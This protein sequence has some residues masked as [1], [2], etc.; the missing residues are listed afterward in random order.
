[1]FGARAFEAVYRLFK[2]YEGDMKP[3]KK[4]VLAV[5]KACDVPMVGKESGDLKIQSF[6]E[7]L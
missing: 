5:L 7:G 3:A 4:K 2:P 6:V 1:M